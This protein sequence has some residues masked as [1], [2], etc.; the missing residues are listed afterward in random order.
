MS[1]KSQQIYDVLKNTFVLPTFEDEVNK[2]ELGTNKDYFL[3][4]YGDIKS[5]QSKGNLSQEF[6]VV[7]ISEDNPN[8][9]PT[10]LDIITTMEKVSGVTFDR[11]IKERIQKNEVYDYID[12]VTLIFKRK[13][14]YEC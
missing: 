4:A 9:E 11:T 8:V 3:I 6:Y 12:R 1:K 7:Y 13:L 2:E 14:M 5:T 10:T